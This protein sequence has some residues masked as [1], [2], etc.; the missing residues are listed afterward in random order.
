MSQVPRPVRVVILYSAGHLG[1]ALT[2]N[3]LVD[4]HEI[5]IVGVVRAQPLSLSRQGRSRVKRHLRQVGWRFAW[6]LFF[7]RVIQGLGYT[8][9][10]MMPATRKRLLPAWKI[11]RQ[12][13]IPVMQTRDVNVASTI[14]F[15]QG[16]QPDLLVSA[17]FSQILKSEIIQLAHFGVLNIHPGWLPSYR[18]AM[19]YFWVLHNGSDRGGVTVHWIDEGIDSGEILERR[20]FPIPDNATQETVLMLTAVI[21]TRLLQ[22]VIE[23]L[24]NGQPA[25][26][27]SAEPEST[28]ED[29]YPMPGDR[30]FASYFEQRRFFRI[31]DVLGLIAFRGM[32]R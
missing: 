5:E 27:V 16:C 14:E 18:G 8:L 20:S 15:V 1:S 3:R 31:R 23:R 2:M 4:M 22:R 26:K 6:L 30:E 17:Y 13:N 9:S 32:R 12:R 25:S 24:Q 29:Y 28:Q 7:Q 19:A 21:G 11:A 10:L